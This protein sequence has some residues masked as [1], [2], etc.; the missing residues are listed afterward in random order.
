[1]KQ[2]SATHWIGLTGCDQEAKN[3][4]IYNRMKRRKF[5]KTSAAAA[6]LVGTME[7]SPILAATEQESPQTGIP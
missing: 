3:K 7:I 5:V 1:M 6:G 2:V 4:I